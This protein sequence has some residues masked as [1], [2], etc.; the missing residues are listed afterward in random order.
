MRNRRFITRR[1]CAREPRNWLKNPV[2]RTN[3]TSACFHRHGFHPR[4]DA[5]PAKAIKTGLIFAAPVRTV[6]QKRKRGA[7]RTVAGVRPTVFSA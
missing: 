5:K 2:S 7:H 4:F 3:V 6:G 1:C